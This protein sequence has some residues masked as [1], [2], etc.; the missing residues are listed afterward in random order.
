MLAK[1]KIINYF[2]WSWWCI[3]DMMTTL[4]WQIIEYL[5]GHYESICMDVHKFLWWGIS[6]MVARYTS[7]FMRD[8]Q[9]VFVK[10][11][12]KWYNNHG[13]CKKYHFEWED[14]E[15]A[16]QP[17]LEIFPSIALQSP[18]TPNNFFPFLSLFRF[19]NF[20]F[21]PSLPFPLLNP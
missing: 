17:T 7:R 10:F 6:S 4:Y 13:Y 3:S 16:Y 9:D 12:S 2:W 5:S 11:Y 21:S 1:L 8:L 20:I 19:P 14:E 18:Y 15:K